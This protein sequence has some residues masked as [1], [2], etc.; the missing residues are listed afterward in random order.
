MV[1][2]PAGVEDGST[3]RLADRG[4]AGP[5]GAPNGSLF[6]HLGVNPD[7]T[8]RTRRRRPAHHMHLGM[9][10]AALGTQMPW[11]LWRAPELVAVAAGTQTGHVVRLKGHGVPHLPRPG[12]W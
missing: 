4:P 9:A 11:K 10:Q 5:R 8:L 7:D 12:P 2:V 6:V 3:L 1:E